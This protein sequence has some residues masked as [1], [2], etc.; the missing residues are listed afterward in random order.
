TKNGVYTPSAPR[1]TTQVMKPTTASV[2]LGMLRATVQ[3][4][5]LNHRGTGKNAA[6]PG[7]QVA[8][9]TGTAQQ[10]DP[11]TKAYS[12][13]LTTA[14]FAGVVPADNPKYA[15]AIML[16]APKNG[17]EGGDGAAPLFHQIAA[18]ALRAADVAPSPAPA[19]IYDLYVNQAG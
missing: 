11:R 2:L 14:T 10:I 12:H 4:G 6:I 5:D 1:A 9:K 19:P 13:T 8:G 17:T 7:Y 16:D 15:V 3:T 18:Y